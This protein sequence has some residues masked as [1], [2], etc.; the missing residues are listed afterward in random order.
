M[1]PTDDILDKHRR[2]ARILL[3][4][5]DDQ[6]LLL[7]SLLEDRGCLIWL[8]PGGALEPG[9]SHLEA[10]RRECWEETG[11]ELAG[12]LPHVW[13]REHEWTWGGEPILSRERYYFARVDRFEPRPAQLESYEEALFQDHRWWTLDD[14]RS[15]DELLVPG[16]IADR[17]PRLLCG[18]LPDD[19]VDVGV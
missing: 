2:A 6:V 12:E 5:H 10:A 7:S 9:E 17:L 16:D 11:L 13:N 1:P 18:D 3:A 4:D 19:P 8:A 14:L 15:S